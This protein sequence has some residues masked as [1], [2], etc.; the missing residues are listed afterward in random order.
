MVVILGC[1][2]LT[3]R[4]TC[5]CHWY[6]GLCLGLT[7]A[8]ALV[9]CGNDISLAALILGASITMWVA[10][11]DIIYALSDRD[12]DRQLRL[13]SVPARYSNSTAVLI[14]RACFALAALGL[15]ITGLL[16]ASSLWYWIGVACCGLLLL[17]EHV[18]LAQ[19]LANNTLSAAMG[20]IF[21]TTNAAVSL[22]FF[23]FVLLDTL[24]VIT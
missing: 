24:L 4:V 11:F 16:T 6:L 2:P 17:L 21:F 13:H 3:K 20:K 7:P 1:Y 10:G 22:S 5:L 19:A 18:L 9:A 8:A 12:C 14:S 23:I 15:C